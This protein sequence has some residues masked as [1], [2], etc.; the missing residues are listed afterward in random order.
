MSTIEP[1]PPKSKKYKKIINISNR[2]I[3]SHT[4]DLGIMSRQ[5][6]VQ[7]FISNYPRKTNEIVEE[8]SSITVKP[9]VYNYI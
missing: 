2:P 4:A 6:S 9:S 8:K 5:T 3:K 7:R 1:R